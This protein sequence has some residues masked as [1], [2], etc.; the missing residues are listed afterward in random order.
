MEVSAI[1]GA[2]PDNARIRKNTLTARRP[3]IEKMLVGLPLDVPDMEG[4]RRFAMNLAASASSW[5]VER[6]K[7]R[8][9]LARGA[10]NAP[11]I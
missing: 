11:W 9:S 5:Q 8:N 3:G 1:T 4:L 2:A 10:G 7:V 6:A